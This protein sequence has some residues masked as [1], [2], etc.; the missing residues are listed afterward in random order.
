MNYALKTGMEGVYCLLSSIMHM[1]KIYILDPSKENT[2][3][4][5]NAMFLED[6]K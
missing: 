5:T 2:D 4:D 1:T 3:I 6:I